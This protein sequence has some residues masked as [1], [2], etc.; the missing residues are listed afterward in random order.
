M[1]ERVDSGQ[2][3]NAG[4]SAATSSVDTGC[5]EEKVPCSSVYI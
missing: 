3:D 1:E 5:F 4:D 2:R